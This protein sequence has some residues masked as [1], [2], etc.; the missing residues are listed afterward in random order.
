MHLSW[1][2]IIVGAFVT[3]YISYEGL[4]PIREGAISNTVYSDMPHLTAFVDGEYQG[5]MKRKTIEKQ[6]LLS[7]ATTNSFSYS[8]QFSDIPYKIE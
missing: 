7:Q 1:I 6:L 3:R 4:M 8:D 5:E 2:F